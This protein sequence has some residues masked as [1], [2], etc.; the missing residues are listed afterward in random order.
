MRNSAFEGAYHHGPGG[1]DETPYSNVPPQRAM[2]SHGHLL[3]EIVC[4]EEEIRGEMQIAVAYSDETQEL[5][6]DIIQAKG[7]S[8]PSSKHL[9]DPFVK[10]YLLPDRWWV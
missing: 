3:P 2:T 9:A 1:F 10:V 4:A 5:V 8:P 7:L 6:V